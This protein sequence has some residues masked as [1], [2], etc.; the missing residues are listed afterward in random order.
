[1][2]LV[3]YTARAPYLPSKLSIVKVLYWK[4]LFYPVILV[5]MYRELGVRKVINA[6]STATHLGGSIPDPRVM[7]A[8]SESSSVY[9]I[10]MELQ[11]KIGAEIAQLTGSEAAMVTAGATS[12]LELAAAACLMRGTSLE[13]HSVQPV[14]RLQPIDGPWRNLIQRLPDT[15]WTRNEVVIQRGHM[16]PYVQ[17]YRNVG[18]RIKPVGT[19][20]SCTKDELEDALTDSTSFIA[21]GSHSRGTT[22]SLSDIFRI[23]RKYDIPIVLDAASGVLPRSKIRSYTRDGADLVAISGG[24]QI[25]GP[26]DTGILCGRKDLVEMAKLQTCPFNGVGRSAK[27][28]RTQMVGLLVA[29]RLFLEKTE[30]EEEAEFTEWRERAEWIREQLSGAPGVID[31]SVSGSPW[32]VRCMV[33]F[34]SSISGH[35]LAYEL[36]KGDPSIWVET[37]L[38]GDISQNKIGIAI[39]S[40]QDGEEK[41]VTGAILGMLKQF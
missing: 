25:G 2:I 8:M 15:T 18:C 29:L 39:D 20:E 26:N 14:E 23:A 24:K 17:A 4:I 11:E 19:R 37:S 7:E 3:Y 33:T 5:S 13:E 35:Q 9:V 21:C 10:I 30:D 16:S 12:A 32:G 1:M 38:T 36:R 28:D 6:C 22:V 40:L 27:V 31:A 41:L 34:E